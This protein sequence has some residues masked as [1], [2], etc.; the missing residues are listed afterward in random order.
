AV[1][2]AGNHFG[3]RSVTDAAVESLAQTLFNSDAPALW[4]ADEHHDPILQQVATRRPPVQML[5]NRFDIAS[6]AK[7]LNI[8]T[9][10]N[11][12]TIPEMQ[13]SEIYFR[14]CKEKPTTHHLLN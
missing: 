8:T 4:L 3:I 5:T 11:D 9:T 10:Y 7:A 1:D 12:W 14:I 13:F 6:R 2:P